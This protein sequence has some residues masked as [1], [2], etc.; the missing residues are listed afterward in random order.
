M[1]YGEG[2]HLT[3]EVLQNYSDF[4]FEGD[5]NLPIFHTSFSLPVLTGATT[6][7]SLNVISA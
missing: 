6:H 3:K 2:I 4:V 5:F 7:S 1:L